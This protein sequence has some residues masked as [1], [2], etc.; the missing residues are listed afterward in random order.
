VLEKKWI[1]KEIAVMVAVNEAGESALY[2][3]VEMMFDKRILTC[4]TTSFVLLRPKPEDVLWKVE[5]IAISVV[6]NFIRREYLL[7]NCL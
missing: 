3:P 6:R 5:A 1:K 7:S 2:P 4:S